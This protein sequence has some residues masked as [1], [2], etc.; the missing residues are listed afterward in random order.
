MIDEKTR[1]LAHALIDEI[2]NEKH[3]FWIDGERHYRDHQ[4]MEHLDMEIVLELKQFAL[5]YKQMK[6]TGMKI[7]IR[8]V[9]FGAF[10]LAVFGFLGAEKMSIFK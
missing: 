6:G 4:V 2:K 9:I 7:F 8:L 5:D 3:D 1:E 10:V